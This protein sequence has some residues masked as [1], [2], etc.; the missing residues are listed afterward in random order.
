M[1]NRGWIKKRQSNGS[2]SGASGFD[3]NKNPKTISRS[4]DQ[5]SVRQIRSL[6][7][8]TS[9]SGSAGFTACGGSGV[10]QK[11]V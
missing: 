4:A 11:K 3:V 10:S 2:T 6:G 9:A 1:T 8:P 7:D 5:A